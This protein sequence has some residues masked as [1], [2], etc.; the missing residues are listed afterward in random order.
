[1]RV[2]DTPRNQVIFNKDYCSHNYSLGIKESMSYLA[3][4][5]TVFILTKDCVL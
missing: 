1:M 5:S 3:F 2:I 4:I